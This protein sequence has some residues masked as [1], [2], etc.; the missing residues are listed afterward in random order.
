MLFVA[1]DS[2]TAVCRTRCSYDDDGSSYKF[3][4]A[5]DPDIKILRL[6]AIVAICI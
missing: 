2:V 4:N 5:D 1:T 3:M 6:H